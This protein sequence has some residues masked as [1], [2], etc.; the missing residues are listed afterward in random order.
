MIV[1]TKPRTIEGRPSTMSVELMF[2]S[3]ICEKT[4]LNDLNYGKNAVH[5]NLF[6]IPHIAHSFP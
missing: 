6:L 1:H 2:T 5:V 4:F 3:L